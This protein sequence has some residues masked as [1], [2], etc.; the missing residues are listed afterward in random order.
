MSE[1]NT[2]WVHHQFAPPSFKLVATDF[3]SIFQYIFNFY[4][5]LDTTN[6]ITPCKHLLTVVRSHSESKKNRKNKKM[7]KRKRKPKKKNSPCVRSESR[8]MLFLQFVV[9]HILL[10]SLS[11]SHIHC[12]YP[13]FDI[14]VLM[15]PLWWCRMG[16]GAQ[17]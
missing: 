8:I 7:I 12:C 13:L 17:G 4:Y 14:V 5:I 16:G 11:V 2:G 15:L 3:S 10:C 1:G 6:Y 9:S